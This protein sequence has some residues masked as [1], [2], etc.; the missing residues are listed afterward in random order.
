MTDEIKTSEAVDICNEWLRYLDR[1]AAKAKR[2]SELAAMARKGPE[3]QKQAQREMRRMD[4]SLTVYD[5]GRLRPAVEHL[6]K[7]L[8]KEDAE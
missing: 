1:Q 4:R 8:P 2:L 7:Q 6:L 3:E 5:G